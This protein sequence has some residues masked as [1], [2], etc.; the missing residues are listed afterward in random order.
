VAH[1]HAYR[2]LKFLFEHVFKGFPISATG[3]PTTYKLKTA[4]MHHCQACTNN[5]SVL[6]SANNLPVSKLCEPFRHYQFWDVTQCHNDDDSTRIRDYSAECMVNEV[7]ILRSTEV[8]HRHA[9]RVLKFLFEHVFTGFP[10]SATGIPTTYKLKTAVMHHCQACTNNRNWI[11]C[12]LEIFNTLKSSFLCTLYILST[13]VCI[14][15]NL[16][17]FPMKLRASVRFE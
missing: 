1:R 6:Q 3:I 10:I 5:S 16:N 14:Q 13:S 12:T 4:V 15:A 11:K 2:V 9:Y 7:Q 17:T 8:A